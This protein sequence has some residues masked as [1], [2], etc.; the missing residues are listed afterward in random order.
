M[1]IDFE[2]YSFYIRPGKT[3]MRKRSKSLA[4]LVQN[5]M[6]LKPFDK[7]VFLFC[8]G[9]HSTLR[10]ITWDRN[11]FIEMSKSLQQSTFAWPKD[12]T[13]A[14]SVK[15]EDIISMLKGQNPWRFFANL[16]PKKL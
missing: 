10:A 1:Y 2:N 4:I 7:A 9:N 14:L 3:D 16:N 8:S 13:E 11:G 12:D 15:K 5:E 6:E